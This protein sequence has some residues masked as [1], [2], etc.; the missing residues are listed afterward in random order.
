MLRQPK[1]SERK[2]RQTD[3]TGRDEPSSLSPISSVVL[4]LVV[5]IHAE[6]DEEAETLEGDVDG[7]A[8]DELWSFQGGEEEGG[9]DG[10]RSGKEKE[11]SE[12]FGERQRKKDGLTVRRC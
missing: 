5:H 12:L 3:T 2:K 8:L 11:N 6:S 9:E 1:Q 4:G 10:E 7:C